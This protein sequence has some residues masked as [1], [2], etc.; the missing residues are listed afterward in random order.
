M[1]QSTPFKAC[2][3]L[4]VAMTMLAFTSIAQAA[5]AD[6]CTR[7]TWD[8]TRELAV[9]KQTPEAVTVGVK[10]GADVPKLTLDKLYELKLSSQSAV[11][12]VAKP[13]KP[14]LPDGAQGGLA[15]FRVSTPGKYRIAMT[16]GH[17][18][19]VVDGA[20][21]IKSLDFQGMRGC[22]RPRKIVEFQ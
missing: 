15:Q 11:S 1:L 16:S 7:F 8:V 9:M 13:A 17:W 4:A 22:E 19:D 5:D 20:Q 6:P 18:I 14:T 2:A 21:I 10:A 3:A 12:F